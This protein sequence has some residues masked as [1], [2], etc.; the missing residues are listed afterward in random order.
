MGKTN[1]IWVNEIVWN[2]YTNVDMNFLD[3]TKEDT[4]PKTNFEDR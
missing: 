3:R 1:K 2:S 4:T